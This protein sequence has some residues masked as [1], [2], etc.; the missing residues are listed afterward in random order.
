MQG[1]CEVIIVDMDIIV[2]IVRHIRVVLSVLVFRVF[3]VG[4]YALLAARKAN[5]LDRLAFVVVVTVFSVIVSNVIPG[6][7]SCN[8]SS[9]IE[10]SPGYSLLD[11]SCLKS[12]NNIHFTRSSD[13]LVKSSD[14]SRNH[15]KF[16]H[17]NGSEVHASCN[18]A[19]CL[20]RDAKG[21]CTR[22]ID[23]YY[24][25]WDNCCYF[26]SNGC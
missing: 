19:L 1:N 9:C 23:G 4:V 17:L 21:L 14:S 20:E 26:C 3:V 10:C 7:V 15:S 22:C 13:D 16:R 8:S 6:C 12:S 2:R 5:L 18:N 11:G 25:A 24:V